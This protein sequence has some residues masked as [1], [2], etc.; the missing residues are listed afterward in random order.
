GDRDW[1]LFYLR[2]T[3]DSQRGTSGL[4]FSPRW[5]VPGIVTSCSSAT[6]PR[7][8]TR[9]TIVLAT[10]KGDVQS[11]VRTWGAQGAPQPPAPQ[12]PLRHAGPSRCSGS[13]PR[14]Y[15]DQFAALRRRTAGLREGQIETNGRHTERL[16]GRSDRDHALTA[17]GEVVR[18]AVLQGERQ[19]EGATE[20]VLRTCLLARAG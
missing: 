12:A 1:S 19:P 17:V 7:R 15:R 11:R 18:H 16:F 2:Q 8:P 3:A 5:L 6:R 9:G 20:R 10:V 13:G 14:R 4:G